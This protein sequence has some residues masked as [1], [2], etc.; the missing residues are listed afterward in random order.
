MRHSNDRN[1]ENDYV[2]YEARHHIRLLEETDK[3]LEELAVKLQNNNHEMAKW[4]KSTEKE[5]RAQQSR[6]RFLVIVAIFSAGIGVGSFLAGQELVG[7]IKAY[8]TALGESE[9]NE[10]LPIFIEET[11]T[12]NSDETVQVDADAFP[13]QITPKIPESFPLKESTLP[14]EPEVIEEKD[15]KEVIDE[16]ESFKFIEPGNGNF[17]L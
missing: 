10:D 4:R 7:Q 8:E 2:D 6:S 11:V 17:N 13:M 5:T 16:N 12:E 3:R 15:E 9:I 1:P 14:P